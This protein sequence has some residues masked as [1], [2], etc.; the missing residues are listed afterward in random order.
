MNRTKQ[1]RHFKL[2]ILIAYWK[3]FEWIETFNERRLMAGKTNQKLMERLC[4]VFEL[5]KQIRDRFYFYDY[6]IDQIGYYIKY[7][8]ECTLKLLIQ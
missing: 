1:D 4:V 7:D 5:V 6:N 3:C 8:F 2:L